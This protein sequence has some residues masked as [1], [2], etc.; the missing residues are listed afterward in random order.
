MY[1]V[2]CTMYHAPCT[3]YRVPCTVYRVAGAAWNSGAIPAPSRLAGRR[4]ALLLSPSR[5]EQQMQRC[6]GLHRR[7]LAD[8]QYPRK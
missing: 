1:D 5:S 3:M 2:P 6:N 4:E 8:I 7:T